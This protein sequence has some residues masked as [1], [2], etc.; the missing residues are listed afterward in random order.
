MDV[1]PIG[2]MLSEFFG[3]KQ[4]SRNSFANKHEPKHFPNLYRASLH[5]AVNTTLLS[6]IRSVAWG[7]HAACLG[8]ALTMPRY[9]R[10]GF[11]LRALSTA[12]ESVKAC[13]RVCESGHQEDL[14]KDL[15]PLQT[16]VPHGP[17]TAHTTEATANRIPGVIEPALWEGD[18]KLTP[19]RERENTI[20]DV[21]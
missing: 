3:V 18:T 6:A 12:H 11:D 8:T 1:C 17:T 16:R 10:Y 7:W 9:G 19:W 4:S 21:Y 13:T 15:P 5:V 14:Q 20:C 2:S